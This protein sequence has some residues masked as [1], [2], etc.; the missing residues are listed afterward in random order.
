MS[1]AAAWSQDLLEFLGAY[2]DAF[3]DF[4]GAAVAQLY[5]EPSGIVSDLGY[6]HW[7]T[8][9]AVEVNMRALCE[10]YRADGVRDVTGTPGVCVPLGEHAAF[11][12]VN[13]S[14]LRDSGSR[15]F[16]TAYN[17]CRDDEQWRVRLCTAFEERPLNR[18]ATSA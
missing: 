18:V 11:V 12:T 6:T 8:R 4:D 7:A 16:A 13:W 17:L 2:R 14:L 15:L 9:A 3:R 1:V 5:A 10:L